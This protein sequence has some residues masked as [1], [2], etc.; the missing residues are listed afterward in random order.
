MQRAAKQVFGFDLRVIPSDSGADRQQW[1]HAGEV[2]RRV[3]EFFHAIARPHLIGGDDPWSKYLDQNFTIAEEAARRFQVRLWVIKPA[4]KL[5]EKRI[6]EID[7]I[8][9]ETAIT[10]GDALKARLSAFATR[11]QLRLSIPSQRGL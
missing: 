11:T 6:A 5:I 9:A 7:G 1:V 4:R 8:I 3:T 2:S 10:R